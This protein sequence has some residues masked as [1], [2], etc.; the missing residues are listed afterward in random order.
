MKKRWAVKSP[1]G[2]YNRDFTFRWMASVRCYPSE[3]VRPLHEYEPGSHWAKWGWAYLLVLM[4]PSI[5]G[6]F[7]ELNWWDVIALVWPI[8]WLMW[9]K[10]RRAYGHRQREAHDS[11][12]AGRGTCPS[13][14]P[15]AVNAAPS[16]IGEP[17][18]G[19]DPE[20]TIPDSA[21]AIIGWRAWDFKMPTGT[22]VSF[23]GTCLWPHR[24]RIEARHMYYGGVGYWGDLTPTCEAPAIGCSCGI[25]ALKEQPDRSKVF[26]QVNLWGRVVEGELGWRA[27]YAYPKHLWV[28]VPS[29]QPVE[30][31]LEC[32]KEADERVRDVM[33]AK[34]ESVKTTYADAYFQARLLAD[35]LRINYSVPVD[36]Y[37]PSTPV[38]ELQEPNALEGT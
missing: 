16:S 20:L 8:N 33:L 32:V 4:V 3:W 37:D 11:G 14:S 29:F 31:A 27:Q 21:Q 36:L 30:T 34:L 17:G 18:E 10:T 23:A 12:G 15:R 25:Y 1:S 24:R 9:F 22:L 13:E 26:G 2:F 38:A 7:L 35:R 6:L 19:T 5:I 28:P